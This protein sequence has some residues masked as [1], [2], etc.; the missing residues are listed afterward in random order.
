ML[1]G[2]ARREFHF[3]EPDSEDVINDVFLQL[4]E[5]DYKCLRSYRGESSLATWLTA[6]VRHRCLDHVRL[7]SMRESK[8]SSTRLDWQEPRY[9]PYLNIDLW[10]AIHTLPARDQVLVRLFFLE[11]RTYKEIAKIVQL[12]ENTIGSCIFRAK[13]QLREILLP[14]GKRGIG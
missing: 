6:V 14:A 7:A 11:G 4:I 10:Q 9:D 3:S 12:P 1:R 8:V 5:R 13:V 2:I